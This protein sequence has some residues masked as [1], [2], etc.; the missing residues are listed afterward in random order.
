MPVEHHMDRTRDMM[1]AREQDR[2]QICDQAGDCPS[3]VPAWTQRNP[4]P[5]IVDTFADDDLLHE[6]AALAV[7]A[8]L[9]AA[10]PKALDREL[11]RTIRRSDACHADRIVVG[12]LHDHCRADYRTAI[13]EPDRLR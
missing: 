11:A 3:Q 5:A 2:E 6:P 1:P 10:R 4:Q 7:D 13:R 12:A 8:S 9:V